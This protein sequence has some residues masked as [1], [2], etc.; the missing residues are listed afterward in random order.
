V[1]S[2]AGREAVLVDAFATLADSL[3]AGFDVI[4][5]LQTLVETCRSVL[6]VQEAGILLADEDGDLDVVAST[7]EASTLVETMQL[8]ARSGPCWT[9]FTTAEPVSLPDVAVG[10]GR[11]PEF[12]AVAREQGFRSV[13]AVPLRLRGTVIGTLNLLRTS[14]GALNERDVRV[15]Q[16][17]ADVATIGILQERTLRESAVVQEQLQGALDTRVV[18]EQ[19]K[20]VVAHVRGVSTGEAFVL[21]RQHARSRRLKL[22]DVAVQLVE[23]RLTL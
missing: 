18:I 15:G 11:W 6:D 5:L 20:G 2:E 19:A 1:V 12:A 10:Q 21:I 23:R 9:C 3:V 17:L 22:A 13:H 4:E 16:A 7:S 8:D 14:V